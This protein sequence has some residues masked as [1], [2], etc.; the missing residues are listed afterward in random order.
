MLR[1]IVAAF[2]APAFIALLFLC[3]S[4]QCTSVRAE[5]SA[6]K[7]IGAEA[8]DE[9]ELRA[10][11]FELAADSY[12]GRETLMPGAARAGEY[13][14]RHFAEYR[15]QP[16]PGQE[17]FLVPFTLWESGFDA[18]GTSLR[19][20]VLAAKAPAPAPPAAE[21][22]WRAGFDFRPFPFSGAAEV[23]GEIVFCGYGITADE[24][25]D[26][27]GLDVKGRVALVL[28][29]VPRE[30]EEGNPL[31]GSR[32]ALFAA[33]AEN[34]KAHGAAAILIVTDPLHHP[35]AE[36]LRLP[37][38]LDLDAPKAAVAG[39][40]GARPRARDGGLGD[41]VAL[42]VSQAVA[43]T[44]VAA[45]G[46]NLRELQALMDAGIRPS[47]I[48]IP[49]VQVSA[50][51][52]RLPGA[53]QVTTN[54]VVGFLPG[55]DPVRKNEWIVIGAHYDHVG[56]FAG[57]GDTIYNGADDNASGTAGLLELAQAFASL[58]RAP[59]RS[60]VFAAF[61]GEEK[62]LLGSYSI[63]R[64]GQ[65]P[66]DKIVFMLNMDMIGRN[67]ERPVDV[68]GDGFAT[69]LTAVI[70][71]ANDPI[72]LPITLL[73]H[74]FEANSDHAPFYEAG[75]PFSFF[76][77][78]YHDDYHQ[79]G[80]H[81]DK[82][83]FDRMEKIVRLGYGIVQRFAAGDVTPRFIHHVNWLGVEIQVLGGGGGGGGGAER[84]LARAEITRVE[85]ESRGARAGLA[86]GDVVR[87][88]G[89]APLANPHEVGDL[90]RDVAPGA[91]VAVSI[92]RAGGRVNVAVTRARLGYLGIMPGA[93][94]EETARQLGLAAG[95]GI[96][97]GGF[98][99]DGPARAAGIQA[100]DIILRIDGK[101]VSPGTLRDRL[102]LIGAGE[103]VALTIVRGSERMTIELV[104]AARPR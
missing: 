54:N 60:I 61:S 84:G 67:P 98:A 92:E 39:E 6:A 96:R 63:L 69:E 57:S 23:A 103:R 8:I 14:A 88:F 18:E 27:A 93:V 1:R 64:L 89:D 26:Y 9:P 43:E 59:A 32:H 91:D 33:K 102:A 38:S 5:T 17:G 104:L 95:E 82:V 66:R 2:A 81:P 30:K 3:E 31:V 79:L 44:L 36:D 58:P 12:Q 16:L 83:A 47:T 20:S 35:E 29:H 97:I 74:A 78:G 94:E 85:P 40:E 100:G 90:F 101:P 28:R 86:A 87:G 73:G 37:N 51:V 75:I 70:A 7:R 11:V 49:K 48:E 15:L 25:D 45:S 76:F 53:R 21:R 52:K 77:T 41:F 62:G 65:L 55:S 80:D 4:N 24:R 34:A 56:A 71:A 22:A 10:H 50:A 46:K 42:H 68:A 13:L 19:S 99:E 72:Q